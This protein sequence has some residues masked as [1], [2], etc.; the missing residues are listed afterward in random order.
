MTHEEKKLALEAFEAWWESLIRLDGDDPD[1]R[2]IDCR[3]C[4]VDGIKE[5]WLACWVHLKGKG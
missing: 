2:L 4:H 1:W 3:A 5:G